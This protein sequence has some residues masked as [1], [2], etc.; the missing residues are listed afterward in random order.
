M[1]FR[2]DIIKFIT[3]TNCFV[4]QSKQPKEQMQFVFCYCLL[5]LLQCGTLQLLEYIEINNDMKSYKFKI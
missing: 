1:N 5:H 2:S 3:R 4:S